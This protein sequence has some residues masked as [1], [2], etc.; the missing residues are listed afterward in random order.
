[1]TETTR[2][3]MYPKNRK[4][5]TEAFLEVYSSSP[6]KEKLINDFGQKYYDEV[7]KI[8]QQRLDSDD[9][10]IGPQ[11]VKEWEELRNQLK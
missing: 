5:Y 2:K 8:H 11:S 9:F 3:L 6:W 4:E 1:M 10:N 7:I